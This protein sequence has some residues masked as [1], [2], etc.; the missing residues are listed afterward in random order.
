[1]DSSSFVASCI[2]RYISSWVS[3]QRRQLPGHLVINTRTI[4]AREL[5]IGMLMVVQSHPDAEAVASGVSLDIAFTKVA[6]RIKTAEP[7]NGEVIFTFADDIEPPVRTVDAD[8]PVEA[9][10]LVWLEPR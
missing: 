7:G 6:R 10:V 2:L 3:S 4:P 8:E 9:H 1:M 5:D